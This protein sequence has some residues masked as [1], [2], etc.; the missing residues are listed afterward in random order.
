MSN[1]LERQ[2]DEEPFDALK[3][4]QKMLDSINKPPQPF[5]RFHVSDVIEEG[6]P[7]KQGQEGECDLFLIALLQFYPDGEPYRLTDG[8][9]SWAH[10]FLI[11]NDQ[12]LDS[13][14]ITTP[15]NLLAQF[16]HDGPPLKIEPVAID[17]IAKAFAMHRNPDQR[18]RYLAHFKKYIEEHLGS[19][20][21]AAATP[22]RLKDKP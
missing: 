4:L 2:D 3:H 18:N 15:E 5:E 6:D 7:V 20:F 1:N 13:N 12:C 9:D 22:R 19:K 8:H 14:G 16:T 10:V 21:P 11:Y 17:K